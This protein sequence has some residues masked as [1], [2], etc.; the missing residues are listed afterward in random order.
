MRILND[1]KWRVQN[2]EYF[3]SNEIFGAI[4][5]RCAITPLPKFSMKVGE[6][7]KR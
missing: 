5:P 1:M 6:F 7:S 3:D 2:E 4:T